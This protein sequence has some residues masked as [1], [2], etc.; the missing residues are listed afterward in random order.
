M[1]ANRVPLHCSVRLLLSCLF[2]SLV[3]TYDREGSNIQIARALV[4]LNC[5]LLREQRGSI[6]ESKKEA[7]SI[8]Y[9]FE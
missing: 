7:S 8:E 5:Q 2:V 1:P 3:R 4:H 6:S 9:T